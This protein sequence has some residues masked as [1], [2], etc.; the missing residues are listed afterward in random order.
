MRLAILD[1]NDVVLTFADNS[2]GSAL[3]F[4]GDKL[5]TYLQGG[6]NTLEATFPT[7]HPDAE[8]LAVGNKLAFVYRGRDYYLNIVETEQGETT[9]DVLAYSG[10]LELINERCGEYAGT[11]KSFAEYLTAFDS[12]GVLTLGLNEVSDK[13]IS[14]E[15]TGEE[16][17]LA[18]LFSLANVFDAE[19]E[20]VPLL[21]NDHSLGAL[22]LNVYRAHSETSQGIG[23][24]RTNTV[25]RYGKEIDGI[26][27]KMSITDLFTAIK[28]TGAN[29]ITLASLAPRTV[30][31]ENGVL[32]YELKAD[33]VIYAPR[34][35]DVFPSN[36]GTNG[37][38]ITKPFSYD[39][40]KKE[41]LYGMALSELKSGCEPVTT[42]DANGFI[43]CDLGDTF[44][45][46][47]RDFNPPLYLQARVIEQE[48]S[49]SD[50]SQN[51]TT[52]GNYKAITAELSAGILE[53]VKALLDANPT[54]RLE[55][56]SDR[57]RTF[58]E[59][60]INTTLTA[61]VYRNNELLTYSDVL[62]A[63]LR[64]VWTKADGTTETGETLTVSTES[65][66]ATI[67]AVLEDAN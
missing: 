54:Y 21:N 44:T 52:F 20:F 49:F 51:K 42:Y 25:L 27:K 53:R 24:D 33:G 10:N 31:D 56:I 14:N 50:G 67:R 16:T 18:R 22:V 19:V 66:S 38:Y 30:Y 65:K 36:M 37:R 61:R 46:E 48:I 5:H 34:A 55:V 6:A 57:G 12:D 4:W 60:A 59:S 43:D 58:D 17:L 35:R 39:T 7:D 2:A 8:F 41:T 62:G 29:G 15:W 23:N 1:K 64:V 3:P 26:T 32:L 13:R 47:D 28:A 63:G 9:I 11:S 40:D 45:I